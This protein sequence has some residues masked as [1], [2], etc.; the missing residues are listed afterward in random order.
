M[1]QK[2]SLKEAIKNP[3]I[4][5]VVGGLLGNPLSYKGNATGLWKNLDSGIYKVDTISEDG[6]SDAYQYGVLIVINGDKTNGHGML[7]YKPV[8]TTGSNSNKLYINSLVNYS[9]SISLR[10]WEIY[11]S[12]YL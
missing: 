7:I 5:S 12:T 11:T 8:G 9:G 2:K 3:E 10:G 1:I 6:P 4:I